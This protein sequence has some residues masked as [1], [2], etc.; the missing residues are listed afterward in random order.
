MLIYYVLSDVVFKPQIIGRLPIITLGLF[1]ISVV[2]SHQIPGY[3]RGQR[4]APKR[5]Q[6]LS[7]TR[8]NERELPK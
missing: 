6:V 3:R 2:L 5:P 8:S 4:F 1:H 7:L